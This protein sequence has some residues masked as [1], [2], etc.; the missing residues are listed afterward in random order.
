MFFITF[1]SSRRR[2]TRC[3]SDWSSDVCSSDL[4]VVALLL[5]VRRMEPGPSPTP[6][7]SGLSD[8][9][10]P[11][12]SLVPLLRRSRHWYHFSVLHPYRPVAVIDRHPGRPDRSISEVQ[13]DHLNIPASLQVFL[14][15]GCEDRV[16]IHNHDQTFLFV[17]G[18]RIGLRVGEHLELLA[19]A[20]D[21]CDYAKEIDDVQ[22]N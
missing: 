9:P 12:V 8:S 19:A 21:L 10:I 18:L 17:A 2:H 3:L 11:C 20:L 16:H 5:P 6:N 22:F 4:V 13:P 1:F 7:A 14:G 15:A